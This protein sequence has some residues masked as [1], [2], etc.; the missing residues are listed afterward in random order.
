MLRRAAAPFAGLL[1]AG[2]AGLLMARVP[3][4]S[5]C[6]HPG[7]DVVRCYEKRCGRAIA[8]LA[9]LTLLAV[10]A[11]ACETTPTAA[12]RGPTEGCN[13]SKCHAEIEQIHYGGPALS[14]VDC[15]GGDPRATTKA[16]AHVTVDTSLNPSTPGKHFL[17][18]PSLAELAQASTEVLQFLNPADYRVVLRTCGST[19]LAGGGCHSIITNNSLLLNRATL[20]GQL[21]GGGFI[22]G[23]QG[24]QPHYGIVPVQDRFVPAQPP[25]GTVTHLDPLPADPPATA[26]SV[27]AKAFYPVYEQ[28]CADCH[29]GR[30]GSKVPGRYYSAGC[31][32][33]HMTTADESR[34]ATA[35]PTQNRDE[36]GHPLKHRFTNLIPDSQCAH[37][38]ISH[39]GRSLLARGVRERSEPEG[40][41]L[42][43]GKNTGAADPPNAVP[44]GKEN[45]VK[46]KGMLWQY[47][48]PWPYFLEDEDGSNATDE[49]PPDIHTQMGL[50]CIDCHNMREAHGSG[51]AQVRMDQELDVR[52]QSCHGRP[53][54]KAKLMSDSGITFDQAGTGKGS[55]GANPQ[56]VKVI[57]DGSVQQ[58]DKLTGGLHPVTQI[59]QRTDPNAKLYNPRTRMGCQLH[60]GTAAARQALKAEFAALAAQDPA[61]AQKQFP[62]VPPGFQFDAVAVESDGRTE[63]F[64]CHNAWTVNCYGCHMV[65]DDRE[66]YISRVSGEKR[67]GKVKSFGLS[68]MADALAL[69]F[70]S[71]GRITPLVGTSIFFTHI[72]A[73]GNKVIDAAPLTTG[74]GLSGDG[75]VHNP[76]HHHT[77]QKQ[78][79]DCTGC[80]PAAD[81]ADNVTA[82]LRAIGLGTGQF[83]FADGA[84][85]THWLDRLI[86]G[87]YDGDGKPDDP[88]ALGLPSSLASVK[89]VVGTTHM[90]LPGM[91]GGQQP[92][93]LDVETVNR[94]LKNKVLPQRP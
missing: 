1:I 27:T 71:R 8:R 45:Y 54:E 60:A 49:T 31:N 33:C 39:L 35:D 61:A 94:I 52:C 65:R 93:P 46:S 11:L 51:R 4:P 47:G 64:A 12:A 6:R 50:A 16:G 59:T 86:V 48:K 70:N 21:A 34:T 87:D 84:G 85:R 19:T 9:L 92:G 69:G 53:G 55:D 66:T 58:R 91:S 88:I 17:D 37:C 78:P 23:T 25:P 32:G 44:W 81:G 28:L 26:T 14:C 80:H 90:Q 89:R 56:T 63:C 22:A 41:T 79:R 43:G 24:K 77:I 57:G 62:G 72:D 36:A 3:V 67:V 15:H 74:E 68:V 73:A 30:E 38:H 29:L 75:N 7:V 5:G 10:A 42:M 82:V 18:D 40:D 83:T 2:F 13:T 76:V 20:A